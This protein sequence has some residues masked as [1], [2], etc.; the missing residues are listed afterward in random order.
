ML[1]ASPL[2]G[3]V[4]SLVASAIDV[5]RH[6]P[7]PTWFNRPC[8]RLAEGTK[9]VGKPKVDVVKVL[10]PPTYNDIKHT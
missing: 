9:L 10:G 8:R 7:D 3:R 1:I 4:T 2:V 6:G 5:A